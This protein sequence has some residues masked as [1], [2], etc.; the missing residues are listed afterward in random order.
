MG[1]RVAKFEGEDTWV[2]YQSTSGAMFE[3]M[4]SNELSALL[5]AHHWYQVGLT[6]EDWKREMS[7]GNDVA[8][9]V[10]ALYGDEPESSQQYDEVL[11]EM[12]FGHNGRIA[13]LWNVFAAWRKN[14]ALKPEF[15][16]PTESE[17]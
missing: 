16:L 9:F 12:N 14:P 8:S 5:F 7:V 2:V 3:P 17:D 11:T 6:S 4:F 10:R 1:C 15:L 13:D